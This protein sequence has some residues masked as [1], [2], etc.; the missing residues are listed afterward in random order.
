MAAGEV[1]QVSTIFRQQSGSEQG[2]STSSGRI[3]LPTDSGPGIATT[4]AD[5]SDGASA[6]RLTQWATVCSIV[7]V[8][9]AFAFALA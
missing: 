3:V 5:S 7:A 2:V 9:F 1:L 4:A 8:A 6:K